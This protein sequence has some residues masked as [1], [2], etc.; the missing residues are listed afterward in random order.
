MNW[1]KATGCF[2]RKG[3]IR[4]RLLWTGLVFLGAALLVNTIAGG[5][6]TRSQIKRAAVQLQTEVA[7]KAANQVGRIISRKTER[8]KDLAT[9]LSFYEPGAEAQRK[10][11]ALLVNSDR[12][13]TGVAVLDDAGHEVFRISE[14][15]LSDDR[16]FNRSG[17]SYF[18]KAKKG[19]VDVTPVYRTA[20]GEPSVRLS[21]PIPGDFGRVRG[22]VTAEVNLTFLWQ[23]IADLKFSDAGDTY[24]VDGN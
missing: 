16:P 12:V 17:D 21:V 1:N 5:L 9:S 22:V 11:A 23:I 20:K 24:L 13:F 15:R 14:R 7:T 2:P 4:Q 6:Y 19:E 8:L 3:G 18:Q 10:L